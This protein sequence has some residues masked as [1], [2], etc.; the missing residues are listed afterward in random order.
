MVDE[1]PEFDHLLHWVPDIDATAA[2][3]TE[4]GFPTHT[5]PERDGFRNG[6][7]R[8]DERYVEILT[9]TDEAAYTAA[10]LAEGLGAVRPAIERAAAAGGGA[11]TFAVNVTDAAA[12]A[13]RLRAAGHRTREVLFEF[14]EPP[15][16][17]REVFLPDGPSWAPFLITYDPP[18]DRILT[19][20]PEDAFDPGE[21]DLREIVIE[22]P[23]PD[24]SAAWLGELLGLPA[25]G[26]RVPLPGGHVV[27]EQGSA[28]RITALATTGPAVEIDG[29]SL[30]TA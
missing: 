2:R 27:F 25:E 30:R 26:A 10:A 21:Y 6:A 15:V 20:L 12:A 5:G 28:D 1:R 11:L 23:E 14:E 24:R 29:L 17:F 8:L 22:V 7:W 19:G 4:A 13:E 16:S 18:R 9:V 3:Y